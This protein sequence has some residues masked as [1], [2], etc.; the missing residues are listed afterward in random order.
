MVTEGKISP[1][2]RLTPEL[3]LQAI[4]SV[5][6][7]P[8]GSLLAL[9][10]YENRV[11]QAELEDKSFVI[12]K[13][14][15]PGRWSNESILEEHQFSYELAEQDIPVICP[16]LCEG[17]SLLEYEGFRFAIYPRRGGRW[18]E[19]DDRETLQQLG[20]LI[21]RIH[22]IGRTA[23]FEHRQRLTVADYGQAS[24]D[25]LL[26]NDFIPGELLH[27]FQQAAQYL[28]DEVQNL[29]EAV[30][31]AYLRIHGDFHP[32]NILSIDHD[33]HFV[34]LD[35][36][37]TG[38]AIQDLWMLLSGDQDEMAG[39]L[40]EILVGYETF[41]EFDYSEITMIEALRG[42][43]LIYYC[44]WLARRWHDPAFPKHFPWFNTPRYWE[45]QMITFREQL[46][47]CHAPALKLK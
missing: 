33:F 25:F 7:M 47:R 31:P 12:A 4:E 42:I 28:L 29:F 22:A 46:E 3:I 21:G 15:R 40:K 18:P 43:R 35:D 16:I 38:P 27:N 23:R 36:C 11:Y 44:G 20:R 24:L 17:K 8:T 6:L 2:E 1:Y 41:C 37:C 9:N 26:E 19:L 39:Q 45:E 5:E 14:Y 30:A 32:G 13:F 10:S 34:D